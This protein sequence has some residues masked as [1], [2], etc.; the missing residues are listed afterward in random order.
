M[1]RD[2]NHQ[3]TTKGEF[4]PIHL[5]IYVHAHVCMYVRMYMCVCVSIIG[6]NMYVELVIARRCRRYWLFA[7]LF[8]DGETAVAKST[9]NYSF[10]VV[11]VVVSGV[12]AYKATD[13][14]LA[15]VSL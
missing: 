2:E 1:A 9:Q 13:L 11:V 12:A 10:V 14:Y 5:A 4:Q 3:I 8:C 7:H 6:K 15:L